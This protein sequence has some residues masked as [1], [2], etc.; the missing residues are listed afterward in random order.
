MA[1]ETP[2]SPTADVPR[3]HTDDLLTAL[4]DRLGGRFSAGTVFGQP[5]ERD[6]VTVIPVATAQFGFGGGSGAD[7]SKGQNGEGGG[8]GGRATPAGY[9][10]LKDG[11]SRFVPVVHP[12]RMLAMAGAIILTALLILQLPKAQPRSRLPGRH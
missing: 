4:A 1:S 10:E 9:I 7:P 6:G 12:A 11:R 2:L 5:V 8:G 3:R